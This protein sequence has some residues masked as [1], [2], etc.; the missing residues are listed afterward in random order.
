VLSTTALFA[1]LF[2]PRA[3]LSGFSEKTALF[4][5]F[6][7]SNWA[8]QNNANSYFAPRAEFNPYAQTWSLGVE[9]QFYAI[10][11]FMIFLWIRGRKGS[12]IHSFHKLF[13]TLLVI[14]CV[15]SFAG[16]LI[17]L[18]VDPNAA[19]YFFG[20]R[21]WELGVGVILRIVTR[22]GSSRILPFPGAPKGFS[23]LCGVALICL[24]CGLGPNTVIP[25]LIPAVIGG[26]L[27]IGGTHADVRDPIRRVLAVP[28]LVWLGK[29]SYS[30]YLW[31]WPVYV[32][33]RWTVGLDRPL[34]QVCAIVATVA[35]AHFTFE[36]VETPLRHNDSIETWWAPARV[37]L[38]TAVTMA[39]WG[40]AQFFFSQ[41]DSLGLSVVSRNAD[42]WYAGPSMPNAGR[43]G[44]VC[45]VELQVRRVGGGTEFRYV[46]HSCKDHVTGGAMYVFGDSH[47]TAYA[48]TFDELSAETGR[49]I[50]VFSFP[51]C[52]YIGFFWPMGQDQPGCVRFVH[53]VTQQVLKSAKDHDVL[54]MPS[55]RIFRYADQWGQIYG[56]NVFKV[57]FNPFADK[58][59]HAAVQEAIHALLPFSK[60]NM[61]MI[62]EAP[63]PILK[64]PPFRC[65]DWFN[66]HNPVCAG[67]DDQTSAEMSRLRE[68]VIENMR[69]VVAEVP[70]VSIWDPFPILCPGTICYPERD[71]HPLFFDG[72][73]ISAYGNIVLYP[74]FKTFVDGVV[75][76]GKGA[77]RTAAEAD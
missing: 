58:R 73:H 1:T 75:S 14:I 50:S 22:E 32:L 34:L 37:A 31:H 33:L 42:E 21:F 45:K 39:G 62:F 52:G 51:G 6:G 43:N 63:T 64:S 74:K 19:F 57:M 35:L 13:S 49:V 46:P 27:L 15:V 23:T 24:G 16:Y 60:K 77:P 10:V 3:W 12:N 11:P 44:R 17:S 69:T 59:R 40:A 71:G 65:S 7:L 5:F 56:Q 26:V 30:L 76:R 68:P 28:I 41:E 48:P 4:A 8:L 72:D 18:R 66:R 70:G 53:V 25:A 54:F 29:R 55:L 47:A 20:Y 67:I 2:I 9:E 61:E 36:Y 38:F